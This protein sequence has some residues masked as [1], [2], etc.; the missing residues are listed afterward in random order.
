[1]R[2]NL[3]FFSGSSEQ[4]FL[5][6]TLKVKMDRE[7]GEKNPRYSRGMRGGI[8]VMDHDLTRSESG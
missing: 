7:G 4:V 1:M 2:C 8:G 3:D 5:E 6:F